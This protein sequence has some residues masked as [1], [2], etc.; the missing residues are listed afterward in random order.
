MHLLHDS[1]LPCHAA[2]VALA[3][4]V[5]LVC[6]R[7]FQETG[8]LENIIW[9]KVTFLCPVT[10]YNFWL[11]DRWD[12]ASCCH[13]FPSR[14]AGGTGGSAVPVCRTCV[15]LMG[16]NQGRSHPLSSAGWQERSATLLR[17]MSL[18]PSFAQ[19]SGAEWPQCFKSLWDSSLSA[20]MFL[21]LK[22]TLQTISLA[23]G[24]VGC[25]HRARLMLACV[26]VQ[27]QIQVLTWA[28]QAFRVY[29]HFE[30]AQKWSNKR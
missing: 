15:L 29:W 20:V 21:G 19:V 5:T 25:N 1:L 11:I 4:L 18:M 23:S 3:K 7:P 9:Q 16:Q 24:E 27:R 2:A 30:K 26:S 6:T 28:L 8:N 12:R 10:W 22:P 13:S 14:N 17:T